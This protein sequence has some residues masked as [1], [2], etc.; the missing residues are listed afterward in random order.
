VKKLKLTIGK[1]ALGG[2][3]IGH[4]EGRTVFVPNTAIGDAVE[5]EVVSERKGIAFARVLTYESRPSGT[6][7][8]GCDAFQPPSFCGGC[9]WL[10][11]P[12]EKQLQA[13]TELLQ[14]LFQPVFPDTVVK[15]AVPS[16]SPRHYRN[17]TFMPVGA[18]EE[19]LFYG[20]FERGSH[21]IVPHRR[22]LIHPPLF[23][24]IASRCVDICRKAGVQ[25]YD[26]GKHGGSLRHIGIRASADESRILLIL[27]TRTAR[28]PFSHLLVKQLTEE[29]PAICGIVQNI[30]RERGN[31]ILGDEEKVLH[32][33]PYLYD[34]LGGLS[35]RI[36]YRSFWQVNNSITA[37]IIDKIKTL[38]SKDARVLDAY[39]GIGSLGLNLASSCREV[40]CVEECREAVADGEANAALNNLANA[41][42]I[43]ARVEDALPALLG[44]GQIPGFDAVVLD[45]PRKG[46]DPASLAAI[47]TAGIPTIVCLSCSPMTLLRDLKLLTAQGT[48]ELKLIQPYDMFPQTWHIETLALLQRK[49][50]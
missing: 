31:V 26:E 7:D 14:E 27:V 2:Y 29:F 10:M 11:L 47:V 48:Y 35:F 21:R 19:N 16:P 36:H 8:P 42:F 37:L 9:D 23:D 39:S 24:A 44:D 49:G 41:G 46:V 5:A 28:L 6:T 13:K 25:A 22:C 15:A 4:A 40:V 1:L 43:N 33:K 18:D 30:N 45:P 34:E 3:G 17:K 12:Y 32:G 50:V 38:L 20:I